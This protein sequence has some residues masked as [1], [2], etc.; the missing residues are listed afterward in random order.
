MLYSQSASSPWSCIKRHADRLGGFT[1]YMSLDLRSLALFRMALGLIIMVDVVRQW[2]DIGA[3]YTDAGVLPRATTVQI[4]VYYRWLWSVHGLHG[5]LLFQQTLFC[6]EFIAALGLLLGCRTRV[7]T[8]LCWILVTSHQA[9][10]PFI[11][12]GGDMLLRLLLFWSLFLPL[13]SRFSLDLRAF[14]PSSR[15]HSFRSLGSVG[16]IVQACCLYGFAVW[17]KSDPAWH[18]C[19]TA[20]AEALRYEPLARPSATLLLRYPGLLALLTHLVILVET[21]APLL[22]LAPVRSGSLRTLA[23]L[24]CIGLHLGM[25]VFLDLGLFP[26]I[27]IVFWLGLLPAYF[28]E[29]WV[30][31]LPERL[32]RAFSSSRNTAP[33][34]TNCG[35]A[36]KHL[37]SPEDF[38]RLREVQILAGFFAVFIVLWN[39]YSTNRPLYTRVFPDSVK[40]IGFVARIDQCWGMFS[41]RPPQDGG[42][43]LP[44]GNRVDGMTANLLNGKAN[45]I[46][47]KPANV[48]SYYP[49]Q[50]W[51]MYAETMRQ[52]RSPLLLRPLCR[53]L[54]ASQKKDVFRHHGT[55]GSFRSVDLHYLETFGATTIVHKDLLWKE[56]L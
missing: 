3:F 53:Y 35:M 46:W 31:R 42:W 39:I 18:H 20:V 45:V 6:G 10:N 12:T 9:R 33:M 7:M 40:L 56:T 47:S 23:A 26:S 37:L 24:L 17:L 48:N 41:P 52:L 1:D 50:R 49:N 43:I 11:L 36:R 4:L 22:L 2:G 14:P 38:C 51:I 15:S 34:E 30:F 19:A 28:W 29:K 32:T 55:S 27:C 54:A 8:F 13:A 21:A 5:S 16:F 25:G 44:V